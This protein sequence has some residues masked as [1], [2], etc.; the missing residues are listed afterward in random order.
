MKAAVANTWT[1]GTDC[2]QISRFHF[3]KLHLQKQA[4]GWTWHMDHS[5]LALVL[6]ISK[7]LPSLW[8]YRLL[9]PSP[10]LMLASWCWVAMTLN[11]KKTDLGI[12]N[13]CL[14]MKLYFSSSSPTKYILKTIYNS[15]FKTQFTQFFHCCFLSVF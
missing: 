3:V 11:S 15:A 1:T 8:L 7:S 14:T 13:Y 12:T 4:V 2:I 9:I 6:A 10:I 5:L